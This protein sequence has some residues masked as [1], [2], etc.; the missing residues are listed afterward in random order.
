MAI[1][2][3]YFFN[4]NPFFLLFSYSVFPYLFRFNFVVSER[5]VHILFC[6]HIW[7]EL[8]LI[9]WAELFSQVGGARA[10]PLRTRLV[11]HLLKFQIL[12]NELLP[13]ITVHISV[14]RA[15]I[16]AFFQMIGQK[17]RPLQFTRKVQSLI[18]NII[19][20]FLYP[21]YVVR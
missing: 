10:P 6:R 18:L 9:F 8:S 7:A 2:F 20:Q 13:L 5:N 16:Q 1:L 15:M 12:A 14:N 3:L 17:H 21:L 19:D 11:P 4:F